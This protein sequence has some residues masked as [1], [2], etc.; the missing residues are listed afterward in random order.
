MD[1]VLEGDSLFIQYL[2]A[3]KPDTLQTD[4]D[5][6]LYG[7]DEEELEREI[8]LPARLKLDPRW[9]EL[10]VWVGGEY[11]TLRLADKSSLVAP[12]IAR[13]ADSLLISI[14]SGRGI[15]FWYSVYSGNKKKRKV[16][17][18]YS[19]GVVGRF[20]LPIFLF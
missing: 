12:A 1:F 10:T 18:G 20:F 19:A 7:D 3:G 8:S 13:T 11:E 2:N 14:S 16:A 17:E 15:P 4:M 6:L 9:N 5:I